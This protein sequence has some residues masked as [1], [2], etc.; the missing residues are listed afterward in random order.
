MFPA[1]SDVR[2]RSARRF[3][4]SAACWDNLV[5]WASVSVP[6]EPEA[7]GVHCRLCDPRVASGYH[8]ILILYAAIRVASEWYY[9]ACC[10]ILLLDHIISCIH[11]RRS[12]RKE[13]RR[14]NDLDARKLLKLSDNVA[15]YLREESQ[16]QPKVVTRRWVLSGH[17]LSKYPSNPIFVGMNHK[18]SWSN[19]HLNSWVL[20]K[21]H[22]GKSWCR[23]L[24]RIL[25]AIPSF[26]RASS[27]TKPSNMFPLPCHFCSSSTVCP[28]GCSMLVMQDR[29]KATILSW[30][31][32]KGSLLLFLDT[33]AAEPT[34]PLYI[35]RN[36]VP[37]CYTARVRKTWVWSQWC[38]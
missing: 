7:H 18:T 26:A 35:F 20:L 31:T 12:K 37:A 21:C 32:C 23:C 4:M 38:K 34:K 16:C 22:E 28:K 1:C 24:L 27:R 9:T 2:S 13:L 14:F 17:D 15:T 5:S 10:R 6:K 8:P 3:S 33:W 36:W 11:A 29:M 30:T 19:P 25:W